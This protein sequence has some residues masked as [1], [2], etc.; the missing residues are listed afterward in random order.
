MTVTKAT[1][2]EIIAGPEGKLYEVSGVCTAIANTQ[3][4]NW[5]LNDGTSDKDL[6]IYG[7]V[8]GSGKYN[9]AS[10]NIEV[11]DV[12][13]VQG[14]YVLYGG[15]TPEFVDA[16]FI[17]VE[18][19]L[20]KLVTE[21]QTVPKE[22][23]EIEVKV[24]Y[25]GAGVF[26]T[27]PEEYRSWISVVDMQQVKGQATKIEPNPADTAVVRVAVQ[28]NDGGNRTGSLS[29]V[30]SGSSVP[31]EF[32]QEGAIIETTADQ[33]NAAEDGATLYRITGVVKSIANGTYGNIYIA[34][35]TGEVYVYGTYDA[36]G[37][38]FDA[39]ATPVKEG[40]IVTVCGVKTS[41]KDSP[42]MKNVT[43]EKHIQVAPVSVADFLAAPVAGDVYYSL[44]GT[45]ANIV[46]DKADPTLQNAYG[47]FDIVDE[48]GSVYV[49]GLLSGWGGPKQMFREL[50]LVEGDKITIVGVRADY[51]GTAQVGNAF[52]VK[53]IEE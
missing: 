52:F 53:K 5:Y 14:S 18:K 25:K 36:E 26:P 7:T 44:T 20:V 49:Y 45:M 2:A 23:A 35:Y 13:T 32:T 46:M 51:K 1:V 29:F 22:G 11:G 10:F 4:G 39:F 38:R 28:P 19:S 48:S 50:N 37:N 17:K 42:Q 16:T 3:Y 27:V 8:D 24:A 9:W 21:T 12:V 6:Y 43:V 31:Y 41:Y 15:N 47:N 33:I 30:S 34:D 40:D